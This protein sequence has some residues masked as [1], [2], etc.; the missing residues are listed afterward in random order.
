MNDEAPEVHFGFI[1]EQQG[2]VTVEFADGRQTVP[3]HVV[4]DLGGPA[5]IELI[6]ESLKAV[7]FAQFIEGFNNVTVDRKVKGLLNQHIQRHFARW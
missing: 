7:T 5:E 2:L 6:A 3:P 1:G 4:E